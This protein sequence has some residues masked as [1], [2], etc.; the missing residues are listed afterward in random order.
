MHIWSFWLV[1]ECQKH[2]NN[3]RPNEI[4]S[5]S[6]LSPLALHWVPHCDCAIAAVVVV[7]MC[8]PTRRATEGSQKPLKIHAK[9]ILKSDTKTATADVDK[10]L[11]VTKATG[12][13]VRGLR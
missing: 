11:V 2:D 4:T 12:K 10:S 1:L 7:N 6:H 8:G 13:P 3:S 9:S 5:V